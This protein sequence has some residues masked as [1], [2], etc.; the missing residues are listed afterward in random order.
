MNN[1]SI[2]P[3]H[4]VVYRSLFRWELSWKLR[5]HKNGL[6]FGVRVNFLLG[7]GPGIWIYNQDSREQALCSVLMIGFL[8]QLLTKLRWFKNFTCFRHDDVISDLHYLI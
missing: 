7:N 6:H 8:A 4:G 3:S 1:A 5:N 2:V